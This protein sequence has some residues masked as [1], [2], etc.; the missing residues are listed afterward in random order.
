MV[1]LWA[2]LAS[3]GAAHDPPFIHEAQWG[4]GGEL[5][6]WTNRGFIRGLPGEAFSLLCNAGV[7]APGGERVDFVETG[8]GALLMGTSTALLRSDDAGCSFVGVPPLD[9]S[10]VL[11]MRRKPGSPL[12]LLLVTGGED[13]A[14]Y[15]S[16]DDGA[17][18]RMQSPIGADQAYETLRFAP[19]HPD[20]VYVDGRALATP[21][22]HFIAVSHDG[23]ASWLRRDL[24]LLESEGEATLL[25]V[26]GTDPLRVLIRAH[27][28]GPELMDRLLLTR[29]GGVTFRAV[30]KTIHLQGAS[31]SSDGAGIYAAGKSGLFYS[32]DLGE[33]F[34][35][36]P[37]PERLTCVF[38]HEG[39][40]YICG[41]HDGVADGLG[42]SQDGGRTFTAVM[43]FG[44]VQAP[45]ACSVEAP[46]ATACELL[47][48]DWAREYGVGQA[49]SADAGASGMRPITP[50]G[51]GS[52]L[53]AGGPGLPEPRADAGA[54]L[55]GGGCGCRL[56]AVGAGLRG[57][58]VPLGLSLLAW[59]AR[60]RRARGP[61]PS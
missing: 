39:A 36:R 26:D 57:P 33:T 19:N 42:R 45:P 4:A 34:T 43:D 22:T 46:T 18:W 27:D 40:L 37:G 3:R 10:P 24:P 14:V 25:A 15:A 61:R 30:L 50:P 44:D 58:G 5:L 47:W 7:G 55:H 56:A 38:E 1:G 52:T 41:H 54:A 6:L 35:Q 13:P 2:G 29:D 21:A 31:F 28:R 32:D 60:R 9:V 48:A 23:G 17:S 20:T 49:A 8:D 53:D 12:E 11:A 59:L 51:A 16:A